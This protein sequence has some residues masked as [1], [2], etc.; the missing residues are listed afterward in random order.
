MKKKINWWW[1]GAGILVVIFGI[2]V[3]VYFNYN[4]MVVKVNKPK[5]I[6]NITP[7]AT[8]TPDPLAPYSILLMGYGGGTHDGGKLTDSIMLAQIRPRDEIVKLI[9]IPRDLWIQIP[10]SENETVGKKI[11]EAYVIGLDDRQ[12]PNKKAEF[13]GEAGGGELSKYA[14]EQ[15]VGIK[16]NYFAA[17]DFDGFTKIIDSLGGI[18]VKI[19]QTF[20]DPFYP[21]EELKNDTC[22]KSEEEMKLLEATMSGDKLEQQYVCRYENLHFDKGNQHM[23][24]A[25]AL[26]YARSRHSSVGGGD[27][28]RAERQKLVVTAVR[29]KIISIGFIPKIIPTVQTLTRHITTDVD[30]TKMSELVTK[31]AEVSSYKIVSIA[32]TDTN[33][34]KN[35]KASTGQFILSPKLGENDF[36]EVKKFVEN[37]GVLTITPTTTVSPAIKP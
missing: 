29:D 28:N 1:I 14:I 11:N 16:P 15:V 33:V 26:K 5:E 6:A 3:S 27:F 17:I 35:A 2:M 31:I 4:R 12:Y 18:D 36:S 10:V 19:N 9:S 30:F 21:I 8:P 20:D 24:G 32:L 7:T 25:T 13:T 22:G 23:D 34:L 37:N